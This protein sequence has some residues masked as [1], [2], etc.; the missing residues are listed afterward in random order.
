MRVLV[1]RPLAQGEATARRLRLAGHEPLA[2]PI[3]DIETIA[4]TPPDAAPAALVVTSA[5]AVAAAGGWLESHR[6][7]PAF[8][9]GGQTA[10]AL[11]RAGSV[12]VVASDGDGE[13][14][15]RAIAAAVPCGSTLLHLAGRDRRPEPGRSLAAAGYDLVVWEVYVARPARTLPRS[16]AEALRERALDAVLHYSRRSAR[17]LMALADEA[18]LADALASPV[19]VC[20]S[21]DVADELA[22]WAPPRVAIAAARTEAAL[23]GALDQ[24]ERG[25]A[26]ARARSLDIEDDRQGTNPATLDFPT[27]QDTRF[28]MSDT[29]RHDPLRREPPTIDL[30]SDEFRRAEAA[31]V[32]TSETSAAPG[33]PDPTVE[34]DPTAIEPVATTGFDADAFPK[35]EPRPASE[36]GDVVAAPDADSEAKADSGAED[37]PRIAEREAASSMPAATETTRATDEDSPRAGSTAVDRPSGEGERPP[38]ALDP[39]AQPDPPGAGAGR[40]YVAGAGRAG[41]SATPSVPG[42]KAPS[43]SPHPA[44]SGFGSMLAAALIG[45]VLGAAIVFGADQYFGTQPDAGIGER[46]AALEQRVSALPA[47]GQGA[48][49]EPRIAALEAGVKQAGET[50][51]AA[52]TA[53]ESAARQAAEATNRPAAEQPATGGANEPGLRDALTALSGRVEESAKQTSANATGLRDLRS[54]LDGLQTQVADGLAASTS[55]TKGVQAGLREIQD[56]VQSGLSDMQGLRTRLS[57][58]DGK[59]QSNASGIQ[60]VQSSLGDVGSKVAAVQ[61]AASALDAKAADADK[62]LSALSADLSKLSPAAVQA[63]L[64]VVIAGRLEDSLRTGSPLGPALAALERLGAEPASLD[65]LKP[66]AA[67]PPAGAAALAADFKPLAERMLSAPQAGSETIAE[68]LRRVAE[69]IVTVRAVGDG[70]G[71]DLPGIVA[72]IEGALGRAALSD[73]ATLWDKLPETPKAISADWAKRLRARVAAEEAARRIGVHSLAALESASSQ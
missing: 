64:R 45:G 33:P 44:R 54:K 49:L 12:E 53:A 58:L 72:G 30:A 20:L 48:N 60:A 29:R 26:T 67:A 71:T 14:L 43:P 17:T 42:I 66:Y 15:A 2:A 38:E 51:N 3:L 22:A 28:P 8:A 59:V 19:H 7:L 70:S 18:G 6:H 27:A 39:A 25:V 31:K 35:A 41:S 62:R 4:S 61:T 50:A 24:A 68:K 47:G 46:L 37:A 9:V 10:R 36:A 11:R 69:K 21:Q 63:G 23:L 34:P 40:A 13:A 56:K 65:A 57:D 5:N 73:A 55:A 32:G 52:R 1:V 16:I